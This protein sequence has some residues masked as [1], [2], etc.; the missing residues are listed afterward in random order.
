MSSRNFETIWRNILEYAKTYSEIKTL[1]RQSANRIVSVDESNRI[2]VISKNPRDKPT[3]R[4]LTGKDFRYAWNILVS[5][6]RLHLKDLSRITGKKSVI[7]AFL[8]RANPSIVDYGK[9]PLT[10][11]FR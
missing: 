9:R 11:Y 4:K 8:A 6:K 3:R 7:C 5:K 2:A 10:L 1:S